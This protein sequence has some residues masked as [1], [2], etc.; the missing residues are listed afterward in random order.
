MIATHQPS[1]PYTPALR[2]S[3][4]EAM[5]Q[6]LDRQRRIDQFAI[7]WKDG[8]ARR[9]ELGHTGIEGREIKRRISEPGGA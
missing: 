2:L 3:R 4:Q 8:K 6:C 9:V 5:R 1:S 7:V